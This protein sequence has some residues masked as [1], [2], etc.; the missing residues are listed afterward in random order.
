MRTVEPM[1]PAIP[2][3]IT[4][5]WL[6]PRFHLLD[7]Y[8]G[9]GIT[10]SMPSR[11]GEQAIFFPSIAPKN[12]PDDMSPWYFMLYGIFLYGASE[13]KKNRDAALLYGMWLRVGWHCCISWQMSLCINTLNFSAMGLR[14]RD[15]PYVRGRSARHP[16][17]M[18]SS[19]V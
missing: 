18:C 1:A 11:A 16:V 15:H 8:S 2:L 13:L 14:E 4:S 19:K 12:S 6:Y 3:A 10:M 17:Q 5:A 9:T 7:Q